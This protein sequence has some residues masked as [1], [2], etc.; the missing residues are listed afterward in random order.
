MSSRFFLSFEGLKLVNEIPG[1]VSDLSDSVK[2]LIPDI[3]GA[4]VDNQVDTRIDV[5]DKAPALVQ[6]QQLPKP[7]V[8]ATASVQPTTVA[9]RLP[10]LSKSVSLSKR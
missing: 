9:E 2:G 8:T 10:F 3:F 5:V 7:V 4:E 6:S 1:M